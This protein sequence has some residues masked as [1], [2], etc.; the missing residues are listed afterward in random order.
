M[1]AGEFKT[2][3]QIHEAYAQGRVRPSEVLEQ[4]LKPALANS[5]NAFITVTADAARAVAREQDARLARDKAIPKDQPLFGVPMGIKDAIVTE[6]IRTTCAS[7]MLA[8]YIP[9]YSATAYERL[10]R[11]GMITVGKLNM[12]EF[13][14][15]GSNENSAFGRVIH[16]TAPDRVP[17]GSSGGSAA[18]VVEGSAVATLGSDTGGSVR[19]PA[20][21]CGIVGLKPTY[22]RVSRYGLVAFASSLD[23][24][25]PLAHSVEDTAHVLQVMAGHD[26]MDSTSSREAVGDYV[27]AVEKARASDADWRRMRIGVPRQ[28]F[29]DGITPEVAASVE[30][31]LKWYES[32]G[33]KLVPVDLPHTKYAVSVYY[34]VA[35][36]EASA[37]LSRFDGIRFGYRPETQGLDLANY[38]RKAR[39]QFGPE[40]KRRILLGTFALTSG[41]YDAYY[42]RACQVRRKIREDFDRAFQSVDLIACPTS[43]ITAFKAGEKSHDPLKMYLVDVFTISANLA[44]L[45]AISVPCGRDG[46]GLPIGFQLMA[47]HFHEARLVQAAAAFEGRGA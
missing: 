31:A 40:V 1:A 25:G 37:N 2:I 14:M 22:G 5:H 9:P 18:A 44:S 21:Y 17:G 41:Y 24:I 4:F 46:S 42:G 15:G 12:D 43:P 34:V 11:A 45:P 47:P 19:L 7:K 27:G 33:A 28:Y 30:A 29:T 20:S 8:S 32:Q 3:R 16:P 23:Q 6:G 26:P 10:R 13:A 35:V 39:S 36:S 38:Y